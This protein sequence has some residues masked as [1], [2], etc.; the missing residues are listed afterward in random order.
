MSIPY[1]GRKDEVYNSQVLKLYPDRNIQTIIDCCMGSGGF[2]SGV[3]SGLNIEKKI[4]ME[5][6]PGVCALHRVIKNKPFELL[7]CISTIKY[8]PELFWD[9]RNVISLYNAGKISMYDVDVAK[10][11]MILLYFSHNAMRM[12]PR[13]LESYKKHTDENMR[14]R[15][16]SA[17][18]TTADR[19]FLKAPT[20]IMRLNEKWQDIEILNTDFMDHTYYWNENINYIRE[21]LDNFGAHIYV[22]AADEDLSS[23]FNEDLRRYIWANGYPALSI[24]SN[25]KYKTKTFL[26]PPEETKSP[27]DETYLSHIWV[28]KERGIMSIPIGTTLS[29]RNKFWDLSD[30]VDEIENYIESTGVETTKPENPDDVIYP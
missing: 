15:C 13:D 10:A 18:L 5:I 7:D 26:F 16:E 20:D 12:R 3:S 17:L 14:Y 23:F 2:S 9:C 29:I 11:E 8:S 28:S 30:C 25:K 6:D 21:K 19:I 4:A 24:L 1:W 27:A 22:P